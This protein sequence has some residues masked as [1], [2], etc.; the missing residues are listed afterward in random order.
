MNQYSDTVDNLLLCSE[1][2][3]GA[4]WCWHWWICMPVTWG[5][6]WD[7]TLSWISA[8]PRL[9]RSYCPPPPT[10]PAALP[11][12]WCGM[13]WNMWKCHKVEDTWWETRGIWRCLQSA[14]MCSKRRDMLPDYSIADQMC[15][16]PKMKSKY[17]VEFF[18]VPH[19]I[20]KRLR[21]EWKCL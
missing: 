19:N 14:Q 3:W 13:K 20:R 5:A 16:V 6:L 18:N 8:V 21:F 1:P 9:L 2:L 10:H 15:V 17:K 7:V 11:R 4:A 12:L